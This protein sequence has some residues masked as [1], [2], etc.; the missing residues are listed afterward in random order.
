[1]A[2]IILNKNLFLA[3]G[4]ERDCYILPD[5]NNK[6]VKI[7]HL[8][9]KHN[10]QNELEYQYMKHIEKN[11]KDFSHIVRCYGFIDTNLGKGLVFDRV[12]DYDGEQSRCFRYTVLKKILTREHELK[13]V[14][15]LKQ[16]ILKNNILFIDATLVNILCQRVSD[17]EYKLIIIDGLGGRRKGIKSTL[18]NYSLLFT[19]YKVRKQWKK[20]LNNYYHER[21]LD[22]EY[23]SF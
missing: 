22:V 15:E 7:L 10:N 12:L 2:K 21:S 5:D 13:L 9:G 1:M 19:K 4:G 3:R 8:K 11:L 6:I 16:Y 14:E 17:K 18:Y 20:F 23:G